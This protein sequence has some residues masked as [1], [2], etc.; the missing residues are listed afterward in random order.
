MFYR[1]FP[2]CA[3]THTTHTQVRA[4][5]EGQMLRCDNTILSE[6]NI[7]PPLSCANNPLESPDYLRFTPTVPSPTPQ[8]PSSKLL[9]EKC[10][11]VSGV[12]KRQILGAGLMQVWG[13]QMSR[14]KCFFKTPYKSAQKPCRPSSAGNGMNIYNEPLCLPREE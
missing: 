12:G 1:S 10:L 5:L 13:T 8:F 9:R 11:L 3:S 7:S 14:I 2:Q 4:H 6:K